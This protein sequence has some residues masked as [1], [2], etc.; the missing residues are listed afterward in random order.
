MT[1]RVEHLAEGV[2]RDWVTIYALCDPVDR[3]K[4]GTIRYVGKTSGVVWHRV[5]HHA[6][7]A[8]RGSGLPVHRWVRKH[9][10]ANDPF[11]II[12]LERVP[13]GSDWA[14]RERHWIE[15]C[16]AEASKPL[17]NITTGGEGLAGHS[18]SSAHREKIA[19][20]LRRGSH[21]HCEH[22][23][24]AFWRKPRD[25]ARGHNRFCSRRCYQT[26]QVGKPKGQHH[27]A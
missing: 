6:Y 11:H 3:W 1:H 17:L 27:G 15:K 2:D 16:R 13:A 25:I 8:K 7:A 18:F 4:T 12:H 9:I 10:E 5:R 23:G 24:E 20:A 22:C 26:W 14:A 19:V 21:F